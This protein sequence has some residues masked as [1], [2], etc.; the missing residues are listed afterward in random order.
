M[1][2]ILA[3]STIPILNYLK[4]YQDFWFFVKPTTKL[5]F[6][7]ISQP[8]CN[9]LFANAAPRIGFNSKSSKMLI[10]EES[11][12]IVIFLRFVKLTNRRT[13][14]RW[15]LPAIVYLPRNICFFLPIQSYIN[16]SPSVNTN[17]R[18]LHEKHNWRVR[19]STQYFLEG[20]TD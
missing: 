5:R 6:V 15:S 13:M 7:Q 11:Y 14:L 2:R 10:R 17:A 1:F 20:K 12:R 9:Q 16:F 3:N 19:Q 8:K 4:N 18:Y